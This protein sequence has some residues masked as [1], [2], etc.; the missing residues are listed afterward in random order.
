M[1][2]SDASAASS[3]P[4]LAP[5][6]THRTPTVSIDE[7]WV[8]VVV[9]DDEMA[10]ELVV[11][12]F[13]KLKLQNRVVQAGDGDDAV[14]VLS[15]EELLP[16]LVLLDLVMPGRSGLD[17]LRWLRGNRRLAHVP[18]V[19]LTGSAE[20]SEVD[21]AY[22]LGILCY[23]V[24]SVGFAALQDVLQQVSLPWALVPPV[25]AG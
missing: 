18:V 13:G 23:L 20:L 15:D 6:E 16:A 14:R 22:A 7:R 24:K 5:T 3:G 9:D 2:P 10:R 25:P 11:R 21:E 1:L 19:I 17:V 8:V 12:Y 4:G